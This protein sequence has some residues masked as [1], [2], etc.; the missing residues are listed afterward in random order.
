M[1]L[2][3]YD[4]HALKQEF[5][6]AVPFRYVVIEKFLEPDFALEVARAYLSYEEAL[7][8]GLG[9][10]S[11]NERRKVQLSDAS[12]FPAPVAKLNAALASPEF[13]RDL[14][15]ITGIQ[16]LLPDAGLAGAGMHLTTG[17]GRLDVHVDFN[18]LEET[19]TYRRLNMLIYLN[20]EWDSSWGGAVELWDQQVRVCHKRVDPLLNRMVLFETSDISFH[21][22][23][24]LTCPA[25]R[26]RQSFATYYY[27]REAP[28]GWDGTRH[29]T[30]FRARP[31]EKLQKFF[32]MPVERVQLKA[33]RALRRA[34]K[35]VKKIV[36]K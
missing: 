36:G 28:V 21:G 26:T 12:K 31:D 10:N 3:P 16:S 5:D 14:E 27:T 19:E 34:R 22:V 17:H 35:A 1:V 13:M 20:E 29:G 9:F 25:D 30:I 33:K 2:N 6:S 32:L 15:I 7:A 24:Q 11:V 8:L 18:Y 4:A 23:T